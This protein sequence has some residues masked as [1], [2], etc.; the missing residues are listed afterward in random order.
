MF[1]PRNSIELNE[2][3]KPC[4]VSIVAGKAGMGHSCQ[5]MKI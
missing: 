3:V 4:I 1:V 2:N 5:R